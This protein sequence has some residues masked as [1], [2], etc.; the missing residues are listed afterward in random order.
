MFPQKGLLDSCLA[1]TQSHTQ[2]GRWQM[3][4]RVV[5]LWLGRPGCWG[6]A[7]S[8]V[9]PPASWAQRSLEAEPP[10]E[11]VDIVSTQEFYRDFAGR[12]KGILGLCQLVQ[13]ASS[14]CSI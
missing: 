3:L 12:C 9:D 2:T 11:G 6:W 8:H 4:A 1:L 5:A 13:I 7:V 14:L 10:K